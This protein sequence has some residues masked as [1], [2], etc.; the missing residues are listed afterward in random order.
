[1]TPRKA[2]CVRCKGK[3]AILNPERVTMK[4]GRPALKG[5]CAECDTGMYVILPKNE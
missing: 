3:Q 4:N 2:Y 1:M 5:R